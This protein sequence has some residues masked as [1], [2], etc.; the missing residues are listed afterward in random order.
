[1]DEMKYDMG[2]SATVL[3]H[4]ALASTG[5]DGKVVGI[6]CMAENMPAANAQR[7]GDV[8][9]TLSGKTIEVLNTDA[10]GRLVLSDGLWKVV[11]SS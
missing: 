9:T 11:N 8:I 1:M 10:E 3:N 2:G 6:T 4:A 5:Y 7:P